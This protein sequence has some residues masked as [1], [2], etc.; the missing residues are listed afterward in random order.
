[1][2]ISASTSAPTSAWVGLTCL[3]SRWS[4]GPGR[5]SSRSSASS[6]EDL[7]ISLAPQTTTTPWSGKAISRSAT[8]RKLRQPQPVQDHAALPSLSRSSRASAPRAVV[9]VGP[10]G[11]GGLDQFVDRVG[12][13]PADAE[14]VELVVGR[15]HRDVGVPVPR[16]QRG[17]QPGVP[18]QA[19][20]QR[21]PV[22]DGQRADQTELDHRAVLVGQLVE[23]EVE[24][25]DVAAVVDL[26]AQ[27]EEPPAADPCG[28][29]PSPGAPGRRSSTSTT[30]TCPESASMWS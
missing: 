12:G 17:E 4:S 9:G 15:H 3:T 29:R 14:V 2:V 16:A 24:V 23:V 7:P 20:V 25:G 13:E 5:L 1:M 11:A 19:G 21:G 22:G 18:V 27:R 30:S 6:I 28:T 10:V 26:A 8:P